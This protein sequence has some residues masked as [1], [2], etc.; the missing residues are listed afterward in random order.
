MIS[1]CLVKASE[2]DCRAPGAP[3]APRAVALLHHHTLLPG[4]PLGGPG[5][6]AIQCAVHTISQ[7]HRFLPKV[8]PDLTQGVLAGHEQTL[9]FGFLTRK[10]KVSTIRSA[11]RSPS[12]RFCFLV[13]PSALIHPQCHLHYEREFRRYPP[14]AAH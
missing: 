12:P 8:S 4:A 11:A 14:P 2:A 6:Q 13:T 5:S 1:S 3:R 7:S 9:C 10:G